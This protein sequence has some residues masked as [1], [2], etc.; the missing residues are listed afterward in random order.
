MRSCVDYRQLNWVTK[1]DMLL[2][3]CIDDTLVFLSGIYYPWPCI[4]L[5]ASGHG[6]CLTGKDSHCDLFRAVWVQ[7]D[8]FW[9]PATFYRLMEVVLN[10]LDRNG[11]MVYLDDVL[12]I[13]RTF[14]EHNDKLIMFGQLASLWNL[15]STSLLNSKFVTWVTWYL[16]KEYPLIQLNYNLFWNFQYLLISSSWDYFWD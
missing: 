14:Q 13:G 10:G 2:L 4:W 1:C 9:C 6:S 8:A 11:C 7:E 12:V 3:S 16:Q 15:R 5:V